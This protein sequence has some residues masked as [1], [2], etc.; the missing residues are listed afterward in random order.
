MDLWA[1]SS[2]KMHFLTSP[3]KAP[4]RLSW[5]RRRLGWRFARE[6]T[7]KIGFWAPG[8]PVLY[9]NSRANRGPGRR[10]LQEGLFEAFWGG[11][12]IAFRARMGPKSP[13]D[14]AQ[15]GFKFSP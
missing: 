4:K 3:R 6:F 7:D 2:R 11:Q 5:G 13:K 10:L 15:K 1:P 12:K 9:V 8:N 14:D